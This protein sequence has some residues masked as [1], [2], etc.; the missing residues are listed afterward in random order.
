V[1][2]EAP[3]KGLGREETKRKGGREGKQTL[4]CATSHTKKPEEKDKGGAVEGPTQ[5]HKEMIIYI[6]RNL[7]PKGDG[8]TRRKK[9]GNLERRGAMGGKEI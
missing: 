8:T 4:Q 7:S 1:G 5:I 9:E 6:L 2:G 3:L